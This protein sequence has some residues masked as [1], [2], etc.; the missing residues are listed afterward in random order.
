MM[1]TLQ[2]HGRLAL[3][4]AS[5]LMYSPVWAKR[6]VVAPLP[7]EVVQAFAAADV[8]LSHVSLLA[9]PV[10]QPNRVAWRSDV[11]MNPASKIGRAHV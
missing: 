8:P 3:I 7:P 10:G 9:R 6:P 1:K 4:V 11:T 2:F 5:V